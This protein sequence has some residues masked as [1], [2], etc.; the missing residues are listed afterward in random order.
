MRKKESKNSYGVADDIS[1]DNESENIDIQPDNLQTNST[2]PATPTENNVNKRNTTPTKVDPNRYYSKYYTP[3]PSLGEKGGVMGR[4]SV[5]KSERRIQF[6]VTCT[7]AQK[8]QFKEAAKKDKRR[9]TDFIC[10]ALEEYIENH[11]LK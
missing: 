10:L 2:E 8:E 9:F 5:P 1:F 6:S 11:N 3:K 7:P 4:K